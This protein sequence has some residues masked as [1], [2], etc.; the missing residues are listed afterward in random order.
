MTHVAEI[1][2]FRLTEGVTADAFL[3]LSE[4]IEA[5]VRA[6]PGFLR[7]QLSLGA[8]GSWTDY[9]VWTDME[10]AQAV[11]K[12]F[13]EQDFAP[14][15]MAAIDPESVKMRHEHIQRNMAA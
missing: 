15:L 7:R 6:N 12:T 1:V 11:A 9:V 4:P 8:D 14:A 3:T 13:P 5:F 10:T 2:T